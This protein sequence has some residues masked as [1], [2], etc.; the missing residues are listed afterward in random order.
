MQYNHLNNNHVKFNCKLFQSLLVLVALAACVVSMETQ[1]QETAEQYFRIHGVYPSWYPYGATAAFNGVRSY[2]YTGYPAATA[3][4][5]Y[6]AVAAYPTAAYPTAFAGVK[7]IVS[8]YSAYSYG[9]NAYPYGYNTYPY[10][11]YGAVPYVAAAATAG[12]A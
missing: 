8:P 7:N 6:P 1:D 11:A 10:G 4:T 9:Y 5:G 2:P 12:K 3:Y